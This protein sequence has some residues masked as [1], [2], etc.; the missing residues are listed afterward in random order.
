MMGQNKYVETFTVSY[1]VTLDKVLQMSI[2]TIPKI[3]NT[4]KL[5]LTSHRDWDCTVNQMDRNV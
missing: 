1:F 4:V 5:P 3:Q 2:G